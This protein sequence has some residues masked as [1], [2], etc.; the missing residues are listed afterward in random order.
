[1]KEPRPFPSPGPDFLFAELDVHTYPSKWQC[2][3]KDVY[4]TI[5]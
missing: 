3:I 4:V 2:F 5:P 1:M